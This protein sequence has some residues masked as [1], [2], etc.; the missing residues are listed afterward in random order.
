MERQVVTPEEFG[1]MLGVSSRTASRLMAALPEH[2]NVGT[3][4]QQYH[5]LPMSVAMEIVSG[6][7]PLGPIESERSARKEMPQKN[8][9]KEPFKRGTDGLPRVAYRK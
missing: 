6:K 3:R 2:I 8:S 4:R 9:P 7:R 5:R 1:Q